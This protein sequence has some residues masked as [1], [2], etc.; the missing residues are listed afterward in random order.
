M[1]GDSDLLYTQSDSAADKVQTVPED[2]LTESRLGLLT[3]D[4]TVAGVVASIIGWTTL[5]HLFCS[6]FTRYTS[7]WHCRWVTV[8]HASIVVTLSAWS[9][10]VQGPWPF[11]DPAGPNTLLHEL[12]CTVSIG[13]FIFDFFWCLYHQSEGAVMI[14]HHLLSISGIG[15]V[16]YRGINGTELMATLFGSEITNPILQLRWFL[17]YTGVSIRDQTVAMTVDFCFLILFT[18]MRI[19]IGSFLLYC[20]LRHP[21]PDWVARFASLVI[22]GLGWVFWYFIVCY[23]IRKYGHK[24]NF[25]RRFYHNFGKLN[26]S[27]NNTAK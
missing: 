16:L 5:Y 25:F 19:G 1:N 26:N 27:L 17:R 23:A 22:Y 10:F 21:R 18:V 12:T 9:V 15:F 8:L 2:A 4:R 14:F 20:Y 6:Y 24:L 7:E 3:F 11:T 13:Y